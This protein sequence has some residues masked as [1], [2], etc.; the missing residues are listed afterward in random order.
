[1]CI[2]DRS[3][4]AQDPSWDE[5]N[6]VPIINRATQATNLDNTNNDDPDDDTERSRPETPSLDQENTEIT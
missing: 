2:R 1:M 5:A 6:E 3:D 4:Q